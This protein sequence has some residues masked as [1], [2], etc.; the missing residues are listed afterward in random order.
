MQVP[1]PTPL[2]G[3]MIRMPEAETVGNSMRWRRAG[4]PSEASTMSVPMVVHEAF[5]VEAEGLRVV[6]NWMV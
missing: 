4:E 5:G 1:E 2:P 6:V 3:V